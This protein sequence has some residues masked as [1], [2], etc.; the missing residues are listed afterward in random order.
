MTTQCP[1]CGTDQ[2]VD[3]LRRQDPNSDTNVGTWRIGC[4]YTLVVLLALFGLASYMTSR[5]WLDPTLDESAMLITIL[6]LVF[7]GVV[8]AITI[9]FARWPTQRQYRC[10]ECGYRWT[11][12][13]ESN[14]PEATKSA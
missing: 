5:L 11:P 12:N 2:I 9:G 3:E 1:H 6:A 7:A 8:L 13:S 4:G 14:L 10:R